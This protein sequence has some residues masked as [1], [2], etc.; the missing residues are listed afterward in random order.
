M[1]ESQEPSLRLLVSLLIFIFIAAVDTTSVIFTAPV[2]GSPTEAQPQL[3]NYEDYYRGARRQCYHDLLD[4]CFVPACVMRVRAG[5]IA[6]G[7]I[8]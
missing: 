6:F 4:R 8:V 5:L 7:R 1:M 2:S 3:T